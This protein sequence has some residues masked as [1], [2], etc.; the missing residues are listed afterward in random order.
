M[1][2]PV[3]SMTKSALDSLSISSTAKSLTLVPATRHER[4]EVHADQEGVRRRR[5]ALRVAGGVV[6]G[7]PTLEPERRSSGRKSVLPRTAMS[8]PA[9]MTPMKSMSAPSPI[10]A[11]AVEQAEPHPA[12]SAPRR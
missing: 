11:A 6:G 2:P 8:G 1:V 12:R 4:H 5:R 7:E 9:M 3:L 10:G